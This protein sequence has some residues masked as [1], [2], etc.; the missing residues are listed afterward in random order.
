MSRK[1]AFSK[2]TPIRAEIQ[3]GMR[4]VDAVMASPPTVGAL[5][6][7]TAIG[8]AKAWPSVTTSSAS[9]ALSGAH[10]SYF[11]AGGLVR[12]GTSFPD[13]NYVRAT[14][15]TDG[16]I[17][18]LPAPLCVDFLFDGTTLELQFKGTAFSYRLRVD[19]ELVSATPGAVTATGS[20]YFLPITFGSRAVRRITVETS[21]F[22][23]GGVTTGPNDTVT[24]YVTPSPRCIVIGGSF[25]EGTGA[26]GN[27]SG[28]VRR[29][30]QATGWTDTW[31]SGLG[32]TGYLT[33][34]GSRVKFRDRI[35]T[36]CINFAPDIVVFEGGIN[37][38]GSFAAAAI[39]AE[40]ST[41]FAQV[42]AALPNASLIVLAPMW[43]N[44]A[45]TLPV[46]LL[47]ARDAIRTAAL[48]NNA[49]FVDLLEMP[50]TGSATTGTLSSQATAGA[51]SFSSATVFPAGSTVEIGTGATRERKVVVSV[52]GGGPFSHSISPATIGTTQSNGSAVTTVGSVLWTGTGKVGATTGSGNSDLLVSNDGT[53]PSQA[54]HDMI[55]SAAGRILASGGLV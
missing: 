33:T 24:K 13:S 37:D 5:A 17:A 39:G 26:T 4:L 41:L 32:G 3:R 1:L 46:T 22:V 16:N 34:S 23:F 25:T 8:S 35:V 55:G 7:A 54:G 2:S 47:D 21:G 43:R 12:H 10:F 40:A 49:T 38:H 51:T 6:T 11:G 27:V 18:N 29:F 9:F 42:Q 19:G 28:W 45:E 15:I 14:N 50:Y 20:T 36:D 31:A 53:H 30:A 44:G 48:A 52:S